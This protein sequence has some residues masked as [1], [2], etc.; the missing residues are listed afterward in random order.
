MNPDIYSTSGFFS[1]SII[2]AIHFEDFIIAFALGFIGALGGYVFK[3]FKEGF[4][5]PKK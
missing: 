1:A 3:M 5:D 4:L 2:S